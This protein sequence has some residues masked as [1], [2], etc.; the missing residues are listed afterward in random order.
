MQNTKRRTR[1]VRAPV[2]LYTIEEAAEILSCSG[3]TVYRKVLAGELRA[4]NIAGDGATR[5]K[6][7]IRSDDLTAYI[8]SKT[9]SVTAG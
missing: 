8:E 4:V 5:S 1:T 9:R 3:M 2:E 7:R 6:T